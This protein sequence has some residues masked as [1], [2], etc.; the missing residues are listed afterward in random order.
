MFRASLPRRKVT[1]PIEAL[2]FFHHFFFF[3][4]HPTMS[5][6]GEEREDPIIADLLADMAALNEEAGFHYAY[7]ETDSGADLVIQT[8]N[9]VRFRVHSCYLEAAR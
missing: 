4:H 1:L 6:Q 7:N 5:N 2:S 3:F 8:N 9:D